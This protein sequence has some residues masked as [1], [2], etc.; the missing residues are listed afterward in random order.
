MGW[1]D[2]GFSGNKI[3]ET[4]RTDEMARKGMI[5][6]NA[7]ASAPNCAPTRACLMSGQYPPRHGVYTVVD[8]RHSPGLPHHRII[9]SKSKSDL[10]TESVTIAEAMKA[11]GYATGMF[12][13][14]NLGRGKSGPTTPT[15]QGFDVFREPKS[16][17]FEKDRYFNERGEY[18]TDS[19]TTLGI[20]WMKEHKEKPFF[21]YMAYHA[22]HSP[23]EPK[24]ELV[25]KYRG[26]GAPNPD[27]AATVEV[28]DT[29]VGRIVDAISE[30]GLSDNT[31]VVFH[32]DNGGTRQ[33][34]APLAGGKGTLYEGGLRVPTAIWGPGIVAGETAEP[35]LS[36]DLY[37]TMLEM[38]G[39]PR[40]AGHRLDGVSLAPLLTGREDKLDRDSVF[41]HFPCYIGGG[42]PSSAMRQ[43]DWKI[44]EFFENDRHEVYNLDDDPGETRDLAM[45]ETAKAVQL[46]TDLHAWQESTG[47]PRPT[48]PNP[49]YDPDAPVKRA[50]DERGKSGR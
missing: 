17:G 27:Y 34:I 21:L 6:T 49:A 7:Y 4:P 38:A 25:E 24:P 22:V 37:P 29:N 14:W 35:M 3:I 48:A 50:R 19:L 12:G 8:E 32:S 23:F 10:A 9:S 18:L 13:M 44:I 30:Y 16:L 41:W 42:G 36:M 20:A 2:M 31:V 43:G 15:G 39:I 1:N 47:A 40:S 28:V 46:L 11:G 5:F 26:K 33:Y 45:S